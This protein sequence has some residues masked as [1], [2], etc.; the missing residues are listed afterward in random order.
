MYIFFKF[1]GMKLPFYKNEGFSLEH[2]F[3]NN[4][5]PSFVILLKYQSMKYFS[6]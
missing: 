6:I 1:T 5:Y 2:L 3:K 4:I